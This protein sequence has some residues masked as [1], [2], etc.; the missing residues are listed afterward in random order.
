MSVIRLKTLRGDDYRREHLV[1]VPALISMA[2]VISLALI[3]L[4][5]KKAVFSDPVYTSS[6]DALSIAYLKLLLKSDPDNAEL[7]LSLVKQLYATGQLKQA[8]SAINPLVANAPVRIKTQVFNLNVRLIAQHYF[9]QRGKA[10][11][12]VFLDLQTAFNLALNAATTLPELR[13]VYS[14]AQQWAS[15]PQ[16]LVMLR[17]IIA[18]TTM[19]QQKVGWMLKASKLALAQNQLSAATKWL[20]QA[21]NNS[22][23]AGNNRPRLA[24]QLLKTLLATGNPN[25]ALQK[26][27]YYIKHNPHNRNLLQLAIS[28]AQQ[29]GH[30]DLQDRWLTMATQLEPENMN[31]NRRLMQLKLATGQLKLAAKLADI[32]LQH[33]PLTTAER[34]QIARLYEWAGQPHKALKQWYWLAM[35][36][37]Q[38]TKE[39][40]QRALKLAIGLFHY[41][42]A[43][44][45]YEHLEKQRPLNLAEQK[46]LTGLYLIQGETDKV[47]NS[48]LKYL[49]QH[50]HSKTVWTALAGLY[51][52]LQQLPQA[53]AT[54]ETIDKRFGLTD[55]QLLDLENIYWLL[56]EP[57]K[58]QEKLLAHR[59][60]KPADENAY[61]KARTD[62]AWY[63]D[64]L[65]QIDGIYDFLLSRNKNQPVTFSMLN[66]LML[67]YATDKDYVKSTHL[68]MLGWQ[69]S[70][71][72]HYA[73][74]A[75]NYAILNARK[76]QQWHQ[77]AQIVRRINNSNHTLAL[78]KNSQ[79]WLALARIARQQQQWPQAVNYLQQ[80]A[81]LS[82]HNVQPE[83]SLLW[84]LIE[85]HKEKS[86]QLKT[87]LI[88]SIQR[89]GQNPYLLDA[90]ASGWAALGQ[91]DIAVRWYR[92]SLPKHK[93]DWPWL[94]DYAYALQQNGQTL[95]AW[96]VRRYTLAWMQRYP[97]TAAKKQNGRN[98][99][100]SYLRLVREFR[101]KT[102]GWIMARKFVADTAGSL[103]NNRQMQQ[104]WLPLLTAWSLADNNEALSTRL[105]AQAKILQIK[106]PAWQRLSLALQQHDSTT[107]EALL[108][109]D[110]PLP[111]ADKMQALAQ[112]GYHARALAFGL[113]HL[114]S[115][116]STQNLQQLRATTTS[117]RSEQ[118]NGIK[119][120][121]YAEQLGDI[122][123]FGPQLHY[124]RA[125]DDGI[126]L[127][128][129]QRLSTTGQKSL[130]NHW[131]DEKNIRFTH[132]SFTS[133]ATR[134]W[135][136]GI[137]KRIN[138]SQPEFAF[139]Q[140]FSVYNGL[141][142]RISAG[143]QQRSKIS[144][145][146][147]ELANWNHLALSNSYSFDSRTILN[148][149]LRWNQYNSIWGDFLGQGFDL[150]L[151]L[152]HTLF[153]RTPKWQLHSEIQWSRINTVKQL[154]ANILPYFTSPPDISS[155][156]TD[157]FGRIGF[158]S[159]LQHG[160]PGMLAHQLGS[161]HWLLDLDTGFQ[162]T[163]GRL[164]WGL[165]GGFGWR[166]L[167]D[168]ELALTASYSN[169][170]RGAGNTY[171]IWLGYNKYFGR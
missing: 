41:Q 126:T 116:L 67:L 101:G 56:G 97:Q 85:R 79:Y 89:F 169:D 122:S 106:L 78:K 162:W 120:G 127:I 159:T 17:K 137:D 37:R 30:T 47:R 168:D 152:N 83:L 15:S 59:V 38:P 19:P 155:V 95:A 5:P 87:A 82:P 130:L 65:D 104:N 69:H 22:T 151:N 70:Q 14:M 74:S 98:W 144:A 147:Y 7:R 9:A 92:R 34:T 35:H 54:Y 107:I 4:F 20:E 29:T 68:A 161:P 165:S 33:T 115:T 140:S 44:R 32:R 62:M 110:Q 8:M 72:P 142:V 63:L 6:P 124:A 128:D 148:S 153:T 53:A 88:S 138:G 31:Y 166:I 48:Y 154:P 150:N 163:R 26:T 66:Q 105:Q 134:S 170:A 146:A 157:Q 16:Q 171:K 76:T 57:E 46:E 131:P 11:H 39:A 21:Y 40:A 135:S 94:L 1:N 49:Q 42:Q 167:G 24:A 114:D 91:Y 71:Q 133:T 123:M 28:I 143:L 86:P 158:G 10:R 109:S 27:P 61:W 93:Q 84:L 77:A 117:I 52:S 103:S 80:A 25:K 2:V 113:S 139:N 108:N 58:A 121:L 18:Q 23:A 132:I 125:T 129:T 118:P 145:S 99:K 43:T 112:N 13:T 160:V 81:L 141:T 75:L 60:T 55:R 100:T 136:L 45:L 36:N 164:D 64:D 90:Q 51:V 156:L 50:P 111:L 12:T 119:L 73:L 96:R 3:L 149:Q 102:A